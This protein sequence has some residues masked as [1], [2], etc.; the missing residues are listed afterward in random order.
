MKCIL[1]A[2]NKVIRLIYFQIFRRQSS[3]TWGGGLRYFKVINTT[4]KYAYQASY[5]HHHPLQMIMIVLDHCLNPRSGWTLVRPIWTHRHAGLLLQLLCLLKGANH[6]DDD[7]SSSS[8][9]SSS[10]SS[11]SLWFKIMITLIKVGDPSKQDSSPSITFH[12][13]RNQRG[14]SIFIS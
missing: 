11:P 9:S 7:R 4:T 8:P 5:S 3:L 14:F 2:I 13:G 1:I 12:N 6:Q 10:S